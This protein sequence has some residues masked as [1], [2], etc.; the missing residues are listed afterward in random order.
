MAISHTHLILWDDE[1]AV[2]YYVPY[3]W[4]W[5]LLLRILIAVYYLADRIIAH[6]MR[7]D[8]EAFLIGKSHG[9]LHMLFI[10]EQRIPCACLG[11][12]RL[13]IRLKHGHVAIRKVF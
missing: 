13:Q 11:S 1:G 2:C 12:R 4:I 9:L 3:L 7:M 5:I 10:P 8:I 6:G